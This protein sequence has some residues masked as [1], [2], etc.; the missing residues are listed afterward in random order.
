MEEK[1]KT[2]INYI[3]F[4]SLLFFL[5]AL[6]LSHFFHLNTPLWGAP[7]YFLLY[8]FGQ[9]IFEIS[10][11]ILIGYVLLRNM[12]RWIF[13]C[14]IG[15][16][17]ALLFAH[18]MN[19]TMVRLMDATISYCIKFFLGCGLEHFRIAFMALNLN[20]TIIGII[21]AAL[22]LIPASGIAFY[23]ITHKVA[24]KKPLRLTS[25]Q[26]L[27]TVATMSITLLLLDIIA[28]P[29]LTNAQYNKY[30]KTL[31]LGSTFLSPTLHRIPLNAPIRH[32][33]NETALQEHLSTQ[34]FSCSRHPN[35]FI[36][37]IETLRRDF[38][39]E[40]TAPNL[41][42]FFREQIPQPKAF[43]NANATHLSWFSIFHSNYPYLWTE[44]RD[45][46]TQ[47]SIPLQIF[48]KLGYRIRVN[49]SA[50]LAYFNM[51]QIIFGKN[52]YLIDSIQDFSSLHQIEPC[53]RDAR[54]IQTTIEAASQETSGNLFIV[55]LDSTHSEYSAPE[56][57]EHPFQPAAIS[58]DYL[59][60]SQSS[61]DLELL[62]NR[63]RN[64]IHW[65]DHL[66][67]QFINSLKEKNL[68]EDAAI[69]VMGD[70]GEEFFEEGA[71]F[72]GTHLNDWQTRIPLF[73]KFPHW[74]SN[75]FKEEFI[76]QSFTTHLDIMPTL[77]QLLTQQGDWKKYFDGQSLFTQDRW[78]FILR[79]QNNGL[80]VP[81]EFSI[82]D[83][84]HTL[85]ARFPQ[86][87]KIPEVGIVSLQT[88]NRSEPEL[89]H[90]EIEKLFPSAFLMLTES[91]ER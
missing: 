23:W 88:A 56:D 33:R 1:E 8:A 38:I 75:Q 36:F 82:S 6:T 61:S 68:Y 25:Q 70:H 3:F 45:Q 19:Y 41:D 50:D 84:V 85:T 69:I 9:A 66:F 51:D 54:S 79:V 47:G 72:H 11:F 63:Y 15:L 37:V 34:S 62:K 55:F 48:K 16:S 58:V 73:Y 46:W 74:T 71:L 42:R 13:K 2:E 40:S 14:Y 18:F 87:H 7:L 53:D 64:A 12:P 27:A 49:T 59:A 52:R 86:I 44:A 10:C 26:I 31:P 89:N 22:F 28:E 20:S 5:L 90:Q 32:M 76:K 39:N 57:F 83:G 80:E 65:I 78:P 30:S 43:S 4:C 67:G 21:I 81:Y 29:Y 17:F 77:L 24:K 60:L 91:Q 35:I